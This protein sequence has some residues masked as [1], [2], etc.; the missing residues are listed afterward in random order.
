MP[1]VAI[2]EHERG[3]VVPFV[4][5]NVGDGS[6]ILVELDGVELDIGVQ[7]FGEK[8]LAGGV[9]VGLAVL[10]SVDVVDSDADL[11]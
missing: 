9:G 6:S 7:A 5:E 8:K 4:G 10:R 3:E 11:S 2:L 1:G